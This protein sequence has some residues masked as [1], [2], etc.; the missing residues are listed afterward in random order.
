MYTVIL[1]CKRFNSLSKNLV[2]IK[3]KTHNEDREIAYKGATTGTAFLNLMH[4][5]LNKRS[6][7]SIMCN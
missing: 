1:K 3:L 7:P 5:G 2:V 6:P 4:P